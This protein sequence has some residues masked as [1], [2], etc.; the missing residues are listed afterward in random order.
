M[1]VCILLRNLD[2]CLLYSFL[3]TL[4]GSIDQYKRCPALHFFKIHGVIIVVIWH[5]FVNESNV[6][7]KKFRL[8]KQELFKN[9]QCP[10]GYFWW[11]ITCYK[12]VQVSDCEA[13]AIVDREVLVVKLTGMMVLV[14]L[15]AGG[16]LLCFCILRLRWRG[17]LH[18]TC[19]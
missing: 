8:I 2:S 10:F 9:L 5:L 4:L 18:I 12:L 3:L 11:G 7:R 16:T 13:K 17:Y 15:D 6:C 19:N 14:T 1:S